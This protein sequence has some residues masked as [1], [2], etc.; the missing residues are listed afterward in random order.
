MIGTV[1]WALRILVLVLMMVLALA[2]ARRFVPNP[3]QRVAEAVGIVT[4]E[5]ESA[6]QIMLAEVREL[7]RLHTVEHAYQ[8]V[9]PYDFYPEDVTIQGI[10]QKLRQE[11]GTIEEI[12][13][14]NEQRFFD[15]YNLAEELGLSS[16][17]AGYEFLV[18]PV[19]VSAGFDLESL[20]ADAGEWATIG[21]RTARFALPQAVITGVELRDL[22]SAEYGYPDVPLDPDE[23]QQVASFVTDRIR[24]RATEDGILSRAQKNA[25]ELVGSLARQA[26]FERVEFASQ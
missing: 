26:G 16:G 11:Q 19:I 15:A 20:P 7:Y 25:R 17:P 12:L 5:E 22:S 18:V 10:F 13:S 14:S 4:H 24:Q 9:F 21:E 23:W 8:A 3:L 6:A 1:K 2:I